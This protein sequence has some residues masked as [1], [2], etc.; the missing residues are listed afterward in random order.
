MAGIFISTIAFVLFSNVLSLYEENACLVKLQVETIV[1][2]ICYMLSRNLRLKNVR[3]HNSLI[4]VFFSVI[5]PSNVKNMP[6][7]NGNVGRGSYYYNCRCW[8]QLLE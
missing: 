8:S 2:A 7:L 6:T 3:R 4:H 5:S 1:V